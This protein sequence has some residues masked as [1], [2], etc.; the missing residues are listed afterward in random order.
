MVVTHDMVGRNV[1]HVPMAVAIAQK[2]ETGGERDELHGT[3]FRL[4]NIRAT[5]VVVADTK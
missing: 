5:V 3:Y 1:V 4:A 2:E